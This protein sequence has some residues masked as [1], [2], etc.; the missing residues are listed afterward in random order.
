MS[1]VMLLSFGNI[2]ESVEGVLDWIQTVTNNLNNIFADVDFSILY[3]WMPS[4]I[5]DVIF[6]V[7]AV[8]L[9]LALIGF[10]KKAILFFG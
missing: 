8:L 2:V 10:I 9:V 3:D 5:Q 4:D 7:I 1:P 6:T